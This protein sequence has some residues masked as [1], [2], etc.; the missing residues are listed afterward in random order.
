MVARMHAAEGASDS[1]EIVRLVVVVDG[2]I[3][4]SFHRLHPI[5]EE[6]GI[7]MGQFQTLH[8]VSRLEGASVGEVAR[9]LGVSAPAVCASVDELEERGLVRRRRSEQDA[10]TVELSVTSRGRKVEARA[11]RKVAH[12]MSETV[13]GLPKADVVIAV[14]VF[15]EIVRRFEAEAVAH[16]TASP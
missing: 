6:D 9:H 5:L 2:I 11:W 13:R 1:E 16:A 4:S 12:V 10:R 14:G 7:T 3:R 8:V 15:E